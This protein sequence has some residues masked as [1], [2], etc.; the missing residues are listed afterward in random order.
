MVQT[1]TPAEV[2]GIPTDPQATRR[3]VTHRILWGLA[4]AFVVLSVFQLGI[5]P[6]RFTDALPRASFVWDRMWPPAID[7][8]GALSTAVVESLQI[9]IVG[10]AFGILL[11]IPLALIAARNVT[12]FA[13][14]SLAMKGFAA[15]VRAVPA[16]IWAFL[17]IMAV[18]LGPTAGILALAVNSTGMLVKVYAEALE[19]IPMGP[20]EA[21]QASGASRSH[22]AFQGIL[23]SVVR[24]FIAWSV[25]RLDINVR[26]STILGVVGAG[27][28]GWELTRAASLS[29]YDVALGITVV[30]FILVMATE[31]VSQWLR[32]RVDDDTAFRVEE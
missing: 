26:Y 6:Q 8:G 13:P 12:P 21:L 17:F 7:D 30:I 11:S 28:I 5:T 32:R 20:I 1:S 23:P 24:L 29:R 27:G 10:T 19:E 22:I 14:L 2:G 25:F 18:G 31:A 3:R 16:L 15:F 4:A 9:A